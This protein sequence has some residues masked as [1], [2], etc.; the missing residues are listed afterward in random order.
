MKRKWNETDKLAAGKKEADPDE[1]KKR[2]EQKH[3]VV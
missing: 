3:L 2:A 1:T